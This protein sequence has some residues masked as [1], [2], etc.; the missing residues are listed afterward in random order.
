M[1]T[2]RYSELKKFNTIEERYE[3]LKLNGVVGKQ[4]WGWDR[5]YNQRF[6]KSPEWLQVRDIVIVRDL[7]CDLGIE[8]FEIGSK[9]LIHHMNPI[10]IEDLRSGN[11]DILNPEYL[12][13]TCDRT[14][15]AIHWGDKSLLPQVPIERRPGDTQL[16][17]KTNNRRF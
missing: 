5:Y 10:W 3:Y 17:T 14:H 12:I 4:T 6:Y 16:W 7:G 2:K 9:L 13:T 11:R 8:G 1:R 15:Q